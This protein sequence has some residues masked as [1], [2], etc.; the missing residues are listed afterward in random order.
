MKNIYL[1][2][3]IF[4]MLISFVACSADEKGIDYLVIENKEHKLPEDWEELVILDPTLDAW[5][6]EVLVEHKALSAYYSLRDDLLIN[7]G[8]DIQ[9]DSIYRS[10]AYQEELMER[11]IREYGEE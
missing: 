2:V 10:V 3:V 8:I 1:I 4:L 9:L 5:G 7:E 11:F 6:D